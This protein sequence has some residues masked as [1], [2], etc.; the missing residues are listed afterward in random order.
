MKRSTIQDDFG[1][2][3]MEACLDQLCIF[4][5]G[6][7]VATTSSANKKCDSSVLVP[8]LEK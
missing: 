4:S 8:V 2:C 7:E 3:L 1:F 5:Q 6:L